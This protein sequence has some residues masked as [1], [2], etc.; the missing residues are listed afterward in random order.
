VRL[1]LGDERF[2]VIEATDTDGAVV[3]VA[4]ELPA[5][6][7]LDHG[8]PGAG[9]LAIAR[10]VRAQPETSTARAIVLVPRGTELPGDAEGVDATL[11]LPATSFALLRKVETVLAGAATD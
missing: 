2:R 9:A 3:A 10:T 6:L 8:L 4:S 11:A 1:T 7:L 5:L